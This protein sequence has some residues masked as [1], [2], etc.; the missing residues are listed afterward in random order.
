MSK[1]KHSVAQT[2]YINV[3][4]ACTL[5]DFKKNSGARRLVMRKLIPAVILCICMLLTFGCSSTPSGTVS[6]KEIHQAGAAEIGQNVVVVGTAET[7]HNLAA[8][9]MFRL[10]NKDQYIWVQVPKTEDDPAQGMEVRVTGTVQ[11]KTFQLIGE[12]IYI[13]A[14]KVGVE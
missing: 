5:F 1:R 9:H 10:Y 13:E 2:G 3:E 14:T 7:K 4:L 6:I 11:K 12:V 8:F